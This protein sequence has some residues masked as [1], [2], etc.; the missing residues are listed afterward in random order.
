[1]A[2][3]NL[4]DRYIG[5]FAPSRISVRSEITS[6]GTTAYAIGDVLNAGGL[7]MPLPGASL[8]REHPADIKY[9]TVWEKF[10]TGSSIKPGMTLHFFT[11]DYT[12]PA[13]NAAFVGPTS[14]LTHCGSVT[15]ATGDY[16]EYNGYALARVAVNIRV[17][18]DNN[19]RTV[20]CVAATTG[21]P[22]FATGAQLTFQFDIDA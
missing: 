10:T 5:R 2:V 4:I 20:Y 17:T 7:T 11:T 6:L 21:T 18:P 9:V 8:S 13:Q 22:T 3:S 12:P 1:M 14:F 19:S 16:V 15:I